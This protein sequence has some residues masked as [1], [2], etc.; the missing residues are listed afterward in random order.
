MIIEKL[1]KI[2]VTSKYKI[3]SEYRKIE[4][5]RIFRELL[6]E[7]DFSS[8][9]IPLEDIE[10]LTELLTFLKGKELNKCETNLIKELIENKSEPV[11]NKVECS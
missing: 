5:V 1:S 8:E 3:N 10:K 2:E 11:K 9:E 6:H 7:I 4:T